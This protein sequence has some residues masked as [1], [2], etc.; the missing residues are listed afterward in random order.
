M[1]RRPPIQRTPALKVPPLMERAVGMHQAGRIA[2][3]AE[4]YEKI[5]AQVPNHFDATHLLGVIALQ[6]GRLEQAQILITSALRTNPKP[7]AALNNLG[8]VY[9]RKGDLEL[10]Y[11]QFERVVKLQ[12]NFSEGLANLGTVLRRLGRPREALVPLRR[13][14]SDNPQSAI[15]CNLI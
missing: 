10:A 4:I 11:R 14:H 12:P 3:A 2:E 13:A 1:S 15:V 6:E 9:L 5:I 7:P 8:M